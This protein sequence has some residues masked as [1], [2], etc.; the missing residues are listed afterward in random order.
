MQ[1]QIFVGILALLAVVSFEVYRREQRRRVAGVNALVRS[2][3]LARYG[4]LPEAL[5]MHCTD[6]QLRPVLVT[7]D[8]PSEGEARHRLCWPP[9]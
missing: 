1:L 6:D 2:F 9:E 8:N 4:A 3:L 5:L 7:V